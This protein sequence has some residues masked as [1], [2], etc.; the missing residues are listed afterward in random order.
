MNC[1]IRQNL[2]HDINAT[3]F[4]RID[5][6]HAD[7]EWVEI[8]LKKNI[9]ITACDFPHLL[10]IAQGY[11]VMISIFTVELNKLGIIFTEIK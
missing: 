10:T 4:P 6:M 8:E 3:L 1:K 9:E 11:N 7:R 2:I 5:R